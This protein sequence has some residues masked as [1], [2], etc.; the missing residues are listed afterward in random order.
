MRMAHGHGHRPSLAADREG[1]SVDLSLTSSFL[2]PFVQPA[3]QLV[4]K[5]SR[6]AW[7]MWTWIEA[8]FQIRR[9]DDLNH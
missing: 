2:F 7:T 8:E 9:L 1:V 6:L 5:S 3:W 4:V